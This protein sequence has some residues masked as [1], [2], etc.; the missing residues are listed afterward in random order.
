MGRRGGL[1]LKN[2]GMNR[3]EAGRVEPSHTRFFFLPERTPVCV[4]LCVCRRSFLSATLPTHPAPTHPGR[5]GHQGAR[6]CDGAH[7]TVAPASAAACSPTSPPLAS[8][9]QLLLLSLS[10]SLSLPSPSP[11]C[12]ATTPPPAA[13]TRSS[14]TTLAARSRWTRP[15]TSTNS[16]CAARGGGREMEGRGRRRIAAPHSPLRPSLTHPF[17]PSSPLQV[18]VGRM[19]DQQLTD[20][21][22]EV[23]R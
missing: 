23:T 8:F 5:H 13:M 15:C 7:G 4:C 10:L 12:W 6:P 17:T 14:R 19:G 3:G 16:W 22:G 20:E 18:V 21:T 11:S 9:F 1:A 2:Q